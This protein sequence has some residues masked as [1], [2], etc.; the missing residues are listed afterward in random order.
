MLK[1]SSMT[2]FS[3]DLDSYSHQVRVALSE[4]AVSADIVSVDL[5][6]PPEDF[7]EI[8]PELI[9]PTLV[10]RDLVLT[11]SSIIMEYLDERFPHP[12]LLPVYPV[13]KAK[14]R[15][16]I[17]RMERDWYRL[18]QSIEQGRSVKDAKAQLVKHMVQVSP[19]FSTMPFFLSEEFSMVDCVLAPLLWRFPSYG[20]EL[21]ES[22]KA[23][24]NYAARIFER[25]GFQASLSASELDL[26]EDDSH[27]F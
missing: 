25:T 5:A 1:R 11:E 18:A 6:N 17:K 7:L 26:R 15:L 3:G 16:L 9:L 10:D 8:N 12:P 20:I 21:P 24:E 27:E 13:A 14:S 19:L 23:I 22:C 4:K 2:L